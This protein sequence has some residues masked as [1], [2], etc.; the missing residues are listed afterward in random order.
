MDKEGRSTTASGTVP[1]MAPEL[2]E[3]GHNHG[4]GA[5]IFALGVTAFELLTTVRPFTASIADL[6]LEAQLKKNTDASDAFKDW[7]KMSLKKNEKGIPPSLFSTR[8]LYLL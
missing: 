3:S 1:Y 5:D 7:L 2:R 4:I 6:A 8:V